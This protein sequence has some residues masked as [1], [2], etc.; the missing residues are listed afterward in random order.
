MDSLRVLFNNIETKIYVNDTLKIGEIYKT[1]LRVFLKQYQD[2]LG[3]N[4]RGLDDSWVYLGLEMTNFNKTWGELIDDYDNIAVL[5]LR[6]FSDC[7]L[8]NNEYSLTK[9]LIKRNFEEFETLN[10]NNHGRYNVNMNNPEFH[11][12]NNYG[13]RRNNNRNH[14]QNRN[15]HHENKRN[16]EN[17][18][19]NENRN[20]ENRNHEEPRNSDNIPN[21]SP[22]FTNFYTMD[23][24]YNPSTGQFNVRNGENS[25]VNNLAN[26]ILNSFNRNVNQN[27]L[28]SSFMNMLGGLNGFDQIRVLTQEQIDTL[29]SG[30]YLDLV[31]NNHILRDCTQCGITL[32]NFADDSEVIALP[33]HHGFM[34]NSITYWLKH[35]SNKCPTCRAR[36]HEGVLR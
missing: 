33:C 24:D 26:Q 11:I 5:H 36:V 25:N 8:T 20:N 21:P 15:S 2:V 22:Y 35:R 31:N 4:F 16:N 23:M 1:V 14:H 30:R 9:E 17:Q 28:A 27:T 29:E 18:R 32:E 6:T 3:L 10:F 19:N 12:V 13:N 7:G 34:K